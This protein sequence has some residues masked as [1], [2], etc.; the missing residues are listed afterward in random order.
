MKMFAKQDLRKCYFAFFSVYSV[1]VTCSFHN[2]FF[3]FFF[4]LK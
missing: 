2:D 3:L 1:D 4:F